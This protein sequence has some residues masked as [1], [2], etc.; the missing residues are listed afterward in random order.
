MLPFPDGATPDDKKAR[1]TIRYELFDSVDTMPLPLVREMSS[2]ESAIYPRMLGAIIR[3]YCRDN[4]SGGSYFDKLLSRRSSTDDYFEFF[5]DKN[6]YNIKV[7]ASGEVD[8][9][10]IVVRENKYG[11]LK[12]PFTIFRNYGDPMYLEG[13]SDIGGMIDLQT[14]L[15]ELSNDDKSAIHYHSLPLLILKGAKLPA[16]FI[17]KVNSA[18][19]LDREAEASYLT[20]DNVLEASEKKQESMRRQMTVTSG[21][22]QLSRGNATD[23]GQVR[24][25]AGL[26][27]L[28]QADINEIGLKIPLFRA[29]EKEL[30][31][32]TL[33][34]WAQE[35]GE[36]I[37]E[38]YC[39]VD[40]PE[41]FVGIDS[42]LNA[43]VDTL[44][45]DSWSTVREKVRKY[46]PEATSEEEIDELT[47]L[48]FADKKKLEQ[49]KTKVPGAQSGEKK[50]QEQTVV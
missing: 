8:E 1:G 10:T 14:G 44:E 48:F 40:F 23:V 3:Y 11:R 28:F 32:S 25:G 20:W 45:L 37:E 39:E 29:A 36:K 17:R 38:Y 21:V 13:D 31:Y 33:K 7:P 42:L 24:S 41:D 22:S 27:T 18:L 19:E 6:F 46:H 30:V 47:K 4:F 35:T 12:T 2:G 9:T 34:M 16:N 5:D 49:A 15:N 43:Q 26:K 50:S